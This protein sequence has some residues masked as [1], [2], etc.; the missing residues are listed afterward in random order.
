[1]EGPM[2][3][4][5]SL[6]ADMR[7][8]SLHARCL[9]IPPPGT[10]P[11]RAIWETYKDDTDLCNHL[12]AHPKLLEFLDW[13]AIW[14]LTVRWTNYW[15]SVDARV[16]EEGVDHELE[17]RMKRLFKDRVQKDWG[18]RIEWADEEATVQ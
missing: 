7:V 9:N 2:G 13:M 11:N 16:T 5:R 12:V 8:P 17:R 1:M 4:K 15:K 18:I 6:Y 14:M 3:M 10:P